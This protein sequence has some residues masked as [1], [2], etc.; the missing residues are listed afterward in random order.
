MMRITTRRVS[1]AEHPTKPSPVGV[2]VAFS[3]LLATVGEPVQVLNHL[4]DTA[5]ANLDV[6]AAVLIGP[7]ADGS[8]VVSMVRG[9]P[10]SVVGFPAEEIDGALIDR[11]LL[12]AEGRC[13]AAR[14]Y[15]L[16]SGGGLYGSLLVLD[17]GGE[18]DPGL[19]ELAEAMT[20]LAAVALDKGFQEAEL[21]RT[22]AALKESREA[23]LRGERLKVLGEM[24][25]VV[26]HEVRNPL[27]A[28]GGAL[29]IL[30]GR[31]DAAPAE[32]RIVR[33]VM[34]RLSGL[35]AMITE[36]L[37]Y[38]RPREL[39]LSRVDLLTLAQD[40]A[41]GAASDA[42]NAGVTFRVVGEPLS[43]RGDRAQLGGV[44]LNLVIN[45]VQAMKGS[46][47]VRL[48]V[49]SLG[50]WGEIAVADTG[51]GVPEALR[52]QIF[53]PFFTTRGGGTGLGLAI[54]R[55]VIE[56]HGGQLVLLDTG[57]GATFVVRLP[58][59]GESAVSR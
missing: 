32:Q 21:R 28:I 41:E 38:A 56:R 19:D 13:S 6:G 7:G 4:L 26:T 39:T 24:A 20:D 27:A 11:L 22:L 31:L 34:E 45:A 15:P 50:D 35:N 17:R 53:E 33:R 16:V 54:A 49:R 10:D 12:A 37:T 55:G 30:D 3:R 29:Q 57:P 58:I 52:T 51:P 1:A 14:V 59:M 8:T 40:A 47:E 18:P 48:E 42:A 46:G 5:A 25:A 2:L 44:L 23:L 36:L 43:C 9:L